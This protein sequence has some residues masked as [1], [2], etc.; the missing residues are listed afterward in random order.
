MKAQRQEQGTN[1]RGTGTKFE[2]G[3]EPGAADPVGRG[4]GETT[5]IPSPGSPAA[6]SRRSCVPPGG[7]G[8]PPAVNGTEGPSR[9]APSSAG[10]VPSE[11]SVLTCPVAEFTNE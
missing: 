4:S 3:S 2:P 1:Y 6:P 11:G 10:P 7:P 9:S 5:L 8:S